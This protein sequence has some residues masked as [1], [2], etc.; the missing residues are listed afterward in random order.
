MNY[1]PD[2]YS[3]SE[4]VSEIQKKYIE[5]DD[6]TMML[7]IYGYL[8]EVNANTLQN[9]ILVAS[10]Y[11]N[12]A[13]PIRSKFERTILTNAITYDIQ[14]I[15]AKPATMKVMI[16]FVKST[17]DEYLDNNK[18][19][20][21]DR[22]SDI[23][24]EDYTFHLDYDIIIRRHKLVNGNIIY[25]A[26]Y[27]ISFNN[28][29]SDIVN[30]YLASPIISNI[31]G[32]DY[33]FIICDIRQTSLEIITNKVITNNILQSKTFDVEF[34]NQLARFNI[35]VEE[36]GV[37]TELVP[38]YEGLPYDKDEYYCYYTYINSN[39][40]RVKF[41]RQS[42]QPAL[43]CEI[44]VEVYTTLGSNGN[45]TYDDLLML[46]LVSERF[47]YKNIKAIIKSITSSVDGADKKTTK[48]LQ[49][50]IPKRMLSRGGIINT[51]DLQN[52]FDMIDV[53][54][55]LVVYKKRDNQI[56]RLYYAYLLAKDETGDVVPTNTIDI[57]LNTENFDTIYN[58]R[59]ILKPG[60]EIYYDK[61]MVGYY[62]KNMIPNIENLQECD[63]GCGCIVGERHP[64]FTYG[65]PFITI[66]NKDPL[67]I[68]YYLDLINRDYVFNYEYIN[69]KSIL[70]FIS[71]GITLYKNYLYS[72]DYV[73]R[74]NLTLNNK[75][76]DD[77]LIEFVKDEDG[78]DTDEIDKINMI[79]VLAITS[80]NQKYY[81]KGEIITYND[82]TSSFTCEFRVATNNCIIDENNQIQLTNLYRNGENSPAIFFID[83]K[84]NIAV[85]TYV[86]K[87]VSDVASDSGYTEDISVPSIQETHVMT[88]KYIV[89]EDVYLFYNYSSTINSVCKVEGRNTNAVLGESY[90][91][92]M[93]SIPLIRYDYISDSNR[94]DEFIQYLQYR[95]SYID[96]AQDTM[97]DSFNVDLKFFNTYGP[98]KLFTIGRKGE[99]LDRV[100]L[101]LEFVIKLSVISNTEVLLEIQDS[102]KEYIEDINNLQSI[103][104]SNLCSYI[105]QTYDSDIDFIEFEGINTFN[106]NYQY[107][108][109]NEPDVLEDVPEFVNINLNT[110][111]EPDIKFTII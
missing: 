49:R 108:E 61:N 62:D 54:N 83:Q 55:R 3:I 13:I 24:I 51:K 68:S 6:N 5:E 21:L 1:L 80:S 47:D 37:K 2:I 89:K 50:I 67:S 52:Y 92:T 23:A 25:A 8:N 81:I 103:H 79:P 87:K 109:R 95:K 88:N 30:P 71:T 72:D 40:I 110:D 9:A 43:N 39:T 69:Q 14:D 7:G 91:F 78:K 100:N 17:L 31:Q 64:I 15:N 57:N 11:G 22:Y 65:S 86:D 93:K 38:V 94:L 76:T 46:P 42:Y 4:T 19:F 107:I 82:D 101:S 85:Y 20:V 99:E 58:N 27:D 106:A 26:N 35:F 12:E 104:M 18:Y 105:K 28:T 41:D 96:T 70:Q 98:S 36:N 60:R 63:S 66:V 90:N 32:D 10:E 102:I 33:I 29:L 77:G 59:Y 53:N 73:F 75:N 48:E 84:I 74:M 16:G 45:F 111:M 56:E 97:E 34:E 44:T